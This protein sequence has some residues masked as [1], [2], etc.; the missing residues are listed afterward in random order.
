MNIVVRFVHSASWPW[1]EYGIF[2]LLKQSDP[3][4]ATVLIDLRHFGV[5]T[6]DD[7]RK[8]AL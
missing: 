8:I 1:S 7:V 2:R 6:E 3:D 5:L 4:A